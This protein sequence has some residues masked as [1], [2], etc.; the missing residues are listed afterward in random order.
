MNYVYII[1]S[2][3]ANKFYT[4][5]TSNVQ[6]RLYEHNKGK[7]R[8]TKAGVP[9]QLVYYEAFIN[10]TDAGREEIFLK[11]GKGRDRIKYL[12]ENTVKE[13]DVSIQTEE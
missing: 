7:V 9:W 1:Y 12:L 5:K 10:S 13:T 11:S 8:S 3:A 4:G 6:D 2:K